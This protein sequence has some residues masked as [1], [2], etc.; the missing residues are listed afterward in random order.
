MDQNRASLTRISISLCFHP[1][2]KPSTSL[3]LTQVLSHSLPNPNHPPPNSLEARPA[4]PAGATFLRKR[5]STFPYGFEQNAPGGS[6]LGLVLGSAP[7]GLHMLALSLEVAMSRSVKDLQ[8]S[9]SDLSEKHSNGNHS[10]TWFA[11]LNNTH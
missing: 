6:S 11:P 1:F 10:T 5:R 3:A 9:L 4:Q 7:L 8:R 2:L